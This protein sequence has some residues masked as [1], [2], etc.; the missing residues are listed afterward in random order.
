MNGSSSS[1]PHDTGGG[2]VGT[3]Q[4][5][6]LLLV[7]G[8]VLFV[9]GFVVAGV[10]GPSTLGIGGADEAGDGGEETP[11]PEEDTPTE[12]PEETPEDEE[13]D[14]VVTGLHPP[15]EAEVGE[16]VAIEF[17]V[18]NRGDAEGS[19]ELTLSFDDEE[20]TS[21]EATLEAGGTSSYV[22]ELDTS[23]FDPD[24]YL[25]VVSVGDDHEDRVIELYEEEEEEDDSDWEDDDND[26]EEEDEDDDSDDDWED[27]DNDREEEEEDNDDDEEEEEEEDDDDDEEEEEDEE[28]DEEDDDDGGLFG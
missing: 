12:T 26:R 20:L 17:E 13:A 8:V 18:E 14:I 24:L 1:G 4:L 16:T 23:D 9:T 6:Q 2:S 15:D 22:Y 11:T 25:I 3:G 28:E 19:E 21:Y 7:A 5:H 10:V 27:D